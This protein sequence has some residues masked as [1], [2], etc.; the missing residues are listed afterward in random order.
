MVNEME[1][2]DN[3]VNENERFVILDLVV[4]V[5]FNCRMNLYWGIFGWCYEFLVWVLGFLY[6]V[7]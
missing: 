1:L 3:I 6:L 4:Y 7:K 5:I 2:D